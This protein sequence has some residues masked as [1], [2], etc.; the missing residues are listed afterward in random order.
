[1]DFR[2]GISNLTIQR[3]EAIVNGCAQGRTLLELGKQFNISESGISKLLQIWIDQGGVPKVPKSG[4]PRST[5]RFFDRNVLRLSRVNPRL[6]AVDIARE[7]CD[8]Q[9]PLFVLSVVGFKQLD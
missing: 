9:N 7:L 2:R 4:R 6:T 5:S 1:M 3:Q 8:P